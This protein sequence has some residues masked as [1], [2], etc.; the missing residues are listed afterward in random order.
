[1]KPQTYKLFAQLCESLLSEDSTSMNLVSQHKG[2]SEIVKY[3]HKN[4]Q[5]GHDQSYRQVDK[6]SWDELKDSWHGS[7]AL[8][9]YRNGTGAIRA[10]GGSYEALASTG[11]QTTDP[12]TGE[13]TGPVETFTSGRGGN[14]L[15]FFKDRLGG[16]PQKIFV[17]RGTGGV[18][19]KRDERQ[20][21]KQGA[22]GKQYD[23]D[24]LARKFKPLWVRATNAAIADIK[25]MTY[26]MIKND[27]FAKAQQKV[28]L[29]IKLTEALELFETQPEYLPPLFHSAAEAAVYMAAAHYYPDSTG[30]ISRPWGS[31]GSENPEGPQQLL[32]DISNGDTTKLGTVLGFFKKNLM[33]THR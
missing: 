29:L 9:L 33:T 30:T 7:W 31:W 4:Q 22:K 2:G 26:T 20:K 8:L 14:I 27:A 10:K 5:L 15:D 23:A 1:M 13:V 28:A 18:G 16:K 3:L 17:G 32:K 21:Q 6:I 25:G 12:E 24:S 11:T 19:N